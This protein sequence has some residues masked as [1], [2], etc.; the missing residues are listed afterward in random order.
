MGMKF[1]Y[2]TDADGKVKGIKNSCLYK[3]KL[4]Y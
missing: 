2:D 4:L 3:N 1:L